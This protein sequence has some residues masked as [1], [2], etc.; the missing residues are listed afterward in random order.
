MSRIALKILYRFISLVAIM[1]F[2]TTTVAPMAV[3]QNL[4]AVFPPVTVS[5]YTPALIKGMI[6]HPEDPFLFDFIV[7]PGEDQLKD[8]AFKQEANKLIKYFMASLTVSEKDMWVNLSPTEK[9]RIIPDTF[10][11]TEMGRDLLAQDYLLKQL[12]ASLMY[13]DNET[14]KIFWQHIRERLP[15]GTDVNA[16]VLNKVWI[17]PDGAD[18]Y[19]HETGVFVVNAHLKVM[20]E[21]DYLNR[22]NPGL[23]QRS[24]QA[25][26]IKEIILP[27]IER[28]VNEGKDFANLRQIY[29]AII[30]ATWYKNN[31]RQSLLGQNYVNQGKV[32]GI[33]LNDPTM[34]DKIYQQYLDAFK[35]GAFDL[36]KDEYDPSTQTVITR[37][38]ISGGADF[39]MMGMKETGLSDRLK[40]GLLGAEYVKTRLADGKGLIPEE[41]M[42]QADQNMKDW[43]EAVNNY[44]NKG[45]VDVNDLRSGIQF[46]LTGDQFYRRPWMPFV[47][48]KVLPEQ[49]AL[50]GKVLDELWRRKGLDQRRSSFMEEMIKQN[51][52]SSERKFGNIREN[53]RGMVDMLAGLPLE[54]KGIVVA[55]RV[56]DLVEHLRTVTPHT[57]K[58]ADE[59]LIWFDPELLVMDMHVLLQT[60]HELK[61]KGSLDN[62]MSFT[63]AQNIAGITVGDLLHRALAMV[64]DPLLYHYGNAFDVGIPASPTIRN[65]GTVTFVLS[66]GW[67]MPLDGM[68]E[69]VSRML[70]D[71]P[72]VTDEEIQSIVIEAFDSIEY[73]QSKGLA[74]VPFQ[75]TMPSKSFKSVKLPTKAVVSGKIVRLNLPFA[76]K[77]LD[78]E[79]AR[80]NVP[81]NGYAEYPES[82]YY[83]AHAE[84]FS[85]DELS[86]RF[87]NLERL[88]L[89][90][91]VEQTI[92]GFQRLAL[93]EILVSY[94]STRS[95]GDLLNI[96]VSSLLREK[97]NNIR[98]HA[99]TED[100]DPA[101]ITEGQKAVTAEEDLD[102]KNATP[103]ALN[104]LRMLT[105]SR[106]SSEQIREEL[107]RIRIG[108]KGSEL[109]SE[110]SRAEL[111]KKMRF[112]QPIVPD[113]SELKAVESPWGIL[114]LTRLNN[115]DSYTSEHAAAEIARDLELAHWLGI[116]T[117]KHIRTSGRGSGISPNQFFRKLRLKNKADVS[118]GWMVWSALNE[119]IKEL[120]Q[121]EWISSDGKTRIEFKDGVFKVNGNEVEHNDAQVDFLL[122]FEEVENFGAVFG[123][124]PSE[125]RNTSGRE[126][127]FQWSELNLNRNL[128]IELRQDARTLDEQG[129]WRTSDGKV[130]ITY[131]EEYG[132]P[133]FNVNETPVSARD[134]QVAFY[135]AHPKVFNFPGAHTV[136]PA[137]LKNTLKDKVLYRTG[138]FNWGRLT[139]N[140]EEAIRKHPVTAHLVGADVAVMASPQ[141]Q[142]ITPGETLKIDKWEGVRDWII[143]LVDK[144]LNGAIF[145]QDREDFLREFDATAFGALSKFLGRKTFTVGYEF[146]DEGRFINVSLIRL[147]S[148]IIIE[149][150]PDRVERTDLTRTS[151]VDYDSIV[152]TD[153]V[154][155]DRAMLVEAQEWGW[156]L[157]TK[158]SRFE[159]SEYRKQVIDRNKEELERFINAK[160]YKVVD[161]GTGNAQ[162]LSAYRLLHSDQHIIGFENHEEQADLESN[163]D[164][165]IFADGANTRLPDASI[166]KVTINMPNPNVTTMLPGFIKEARRILKSDG[167][168]FVTWQ[169]LESNQENKNWI[170]TESL[171]SL[172]GRMEQII[173]RSLRENGF[174]FNEPFTETTFKLPLAAID[175]TYPSTSYIKNY[176]QAG[177]SGVNAVSVRKSDVAI[178]SDKVIS[179]D[180]LGG[181][182]LNPTTIDMTIEGNARTFNLPSSQMSPEM[183][184]QG[185]QPIIINITPVVNVP[186]LLGIKETESKELLSS[187]K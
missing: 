53:E 17:V 145:M 62:P 14:G 161:L 33:K 149:L 86:H 186:L 44:L 135:L 169:N 171:I 115:V 158:N 51:N 114:D 82:R 170:G 102:N 94:K 168:L 97:N 78:V 77:I 56:N 59:G 91:D 2:L 50:M 64:L 8:E 80:K 39:S 126:G 172:I 87:P 105:I 106:K 147:T 119:G 98:Q 60:I 9:D 131:E 49:R 3:A 37:K 183:T 85:T 27:A 154:F 96:F 99:D 36:V 157:R 127:L 83:K 181:I 26:T 90:R 79:D 100:I 121:G 162:F 12:T 92:D 146:R 11:Q 113:S 68:R 163:L 84:V 143:G 120:K 6:I 187:A 55:Q 47:L 15:N 71:V 175:P 124:Y 74:V 108:L 25:D 130:T 52:F 141:K 125:I 88:F 132:R 40:D 65:I 116:I 136:I 16:D 176:E 128:V 165:L 61:Q 173:L 41:D 75:R 7:H 177:K 30:L 43:A 31:L 34:K 22:D 112:R 63:D 19:T 4:P 118:T 123:G 180:P 111:I 117:I 122:A 58:A 89:E 45:R 54:E 129:I 151:T 184:I 148:R 29:N 38:Y 32:E 1:A 5:A 18:I 24:I 107:S 10:S 42:E 46:M 185:L 35:K 138:R 140:R 160:G 76:P 152:I 48:S 179:E 155:G 57:E 20:M 13:P 153:K 156:V 95:K 69:Y 182:D 139:Y 137:Q 101:M 109:P 164:G 93:S 70:S 28:E 159:E 66:R 73:L 81:E 144:K 110:Q 166:D 72:G 67:Q 134:A 174:V 142:S 133:A 167:Q 21:G 103:F 104:Y 150:E 23:N 178:V